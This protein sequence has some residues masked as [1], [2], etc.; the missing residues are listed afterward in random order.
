M[1][2]IL[3][4]Y[5][6]QPGAAG[7]VNDSDANPAILRAKLLAQQAKT[8]NLEVKN[9]RL[10]KAL[11]RLLSNQSAQDKALLLSDL[12][13]PNVKTPL[14]DIGFANTVMT[15]L[16]V[17]ER[18]SEKGLGIIIDLDKMLILD[19]TETGERAIIAGPE[20]A[21]WFFKL[22]SVH[23]AL[24]DRAAIIGSKK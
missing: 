11:E 22:L 1:Q 21:K 10:E 17:L 5:G 4:F 9:Y 19:I 2:L 15:L 12:E 23:P 13:I 6:R 7:F 20:R 8:K 24:R 14:A 18:L 3:E 16:S